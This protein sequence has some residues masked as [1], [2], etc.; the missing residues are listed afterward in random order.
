MV[1]KKKPIGT[2]PKSST[3]VPPSST[4]KPINICARK[5]QIARTKRTLFVFS[6]IFHP[7]IQSYIIMR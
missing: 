1:K 3:K 6:K 5:E 2:N 7:Y 4:D